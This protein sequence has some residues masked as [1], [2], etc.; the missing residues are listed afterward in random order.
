MSVAGVRVVEFGTYWVAEQVAG[1]V[2]RWCSDA[3]WS[4]GS[5]VIV[6]DIVVVVCGYRC[7]LSINA[8]SQYITESL[9]SR[10]GPAAGDM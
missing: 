2:I 9:Y 1:K 4:R 8:S 3:L 10:F 5:S 6:V 7:L